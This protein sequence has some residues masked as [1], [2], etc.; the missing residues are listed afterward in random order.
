MDELLLMMLLIWGFAFPVLE[1]EP[2]E[3]A[4]IHAVLPGGEREKDPLLRDGEPLG[5]SGGV[6]FREAFPSLGAD[7]V[8]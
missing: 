1:V 4:A 7:A 6:V 3:L 5:E 2:E 8:G